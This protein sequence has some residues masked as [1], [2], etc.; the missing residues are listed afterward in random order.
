MSVFRGPGSTRCSRV[1]FGVSLG[2]TRDPELVEW[3]ARAIR[4][5]LGGTL[6][7]ARER[8]LPGPSTRATPSNQAGTKASGEWT[9]A[10]QRG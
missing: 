3:A 5:A 8:A 4:T 9:R 1:G 2:Q 6:S 7:A 10:I